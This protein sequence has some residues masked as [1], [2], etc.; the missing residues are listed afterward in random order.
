MQTLL[1]SLRESWKNFKI[2]KEKINNLILEKEE[3]DFLKRSL[4]CTG[5]FE[6]GIVGVYYYKMEGG[7]YYDS[8]VLSLCG[9]YLFL[10]RVADNLID[11]HFVKPLSKPYDFLKSIGENILGEEGFVPNEFGVK[12]AIEVA[13]LVGE[14]LSS[15]PCWEESKSNFK[16]DFENFI[17][18][19]HN[20]ENK[21]KKYE[22]RVKTGGLLQLTI[23]DIV[24][25]FPDVLEEKREETR[26]IAYNSGIIAQL[27]DDKIDGDKGVEKEKVDFFLRDYWKKL[28]EVNGFTT[29]VKIYTPLSRIIS[30]KFYR[31][32]RNILT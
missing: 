12:G 17:K 1:K 8:S 29:L 21:N 20:D 28:K 2:M 5:S 13:K 18:V 25:S 23:C 24:E 10:I 30:T 3:K 6:K 7:K 31:T 11:G 26:R 9:D 32:T 19:W 16:D 27:I 4:A 22:E 15:L 14:E